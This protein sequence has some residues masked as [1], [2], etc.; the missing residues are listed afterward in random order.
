MAPLVPAKEELALELEIAKAAVSRGYFAPDED[1]VIRFRF[2]QYLRARAVLHEILRDLRP[3]GARPREESTEAQRLF[4]VGFTAAMMLV[5]VGRFMVES[6]AS[7]PVLRK[8]LDEAEPRFG[9]PPMQF[10]HIYKTLS[11]PSKV[12]GF[13]RALHYAQDHRAALNRL[14][15]DPDFLRGARS[16]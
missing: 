1:D 12:Y 15:E 13:Y 4:V 9:I 11:H 14:R 8:K 2:A 3:H 6:L 7:E 16:F 5:R 10:S